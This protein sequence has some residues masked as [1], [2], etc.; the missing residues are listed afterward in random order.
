M[1]DPL[2]ELLDSGALNT[3][4][5]PS[6]SRYYNTGVTSLKQGDKREVTYL[7]RRFVPPPENFSVV[8]EHSVVEGDRVDNLAAHYLGD[9]ELY[10]RL[11]DANGVMHPDELTQTIGAKV[12]ITLPENVPGEGDG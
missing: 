4:N 7:K 9:P 5:F 12:V 8:Q 6:N 3:S 1:N 11:C 2:K 10:W